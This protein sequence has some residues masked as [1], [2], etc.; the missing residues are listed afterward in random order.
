MGRDLTGI[1]LPKSESKEELFRVEK[2]LER[3][4]HKDVVETEHI[5]IIPL[6]ETTKGIVN[7]S[8]IVS[9]SKKVIAVAYGAVDFAKDMGVDLSPEG[10]ELLYARSRIA[11]AAKAARVQAIDTP[12]VGLIDK[13]GLEKDAKIAKQ[14]GFNG[15][16]LIHP[17]Q[18][19]LVNRTFS[20]SNEEIEYAKKVV[21]TFEE[22]K[23]KGLGAF[24][25]DGRMIDAASFQQAKDV[26]SMAEGISREG[27]K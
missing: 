18:I 16:M 27:K 15:K 10:I 4:A 22:A 20:P 25:L 24:S 21:E 3:V 6:I 14:L 1:M 8:E 13:Q 26:L 9:A 5:S 17:S 11:I 2:L 12:W 19:V 23:V 7:I